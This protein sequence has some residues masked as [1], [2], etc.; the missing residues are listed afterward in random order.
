MFGDRPGTFP[1][2]EGVA[3]RVDQTV[4]AS[5]K[6]GIEVG[7]TIPLARVLVAFIVIG[8]VG[9]ILLV[10]LAGSEDI[11][12]GILGIIAGLLWLAWVVLT[13]TWSI[14]VIA[15]MLRLVKPHTAAR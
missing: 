15:G 8:I 4:R 3:M 13:T 6:S 1:P 2:G 10:V 9:S 11:P 7:S 12:S 14:A 5:W